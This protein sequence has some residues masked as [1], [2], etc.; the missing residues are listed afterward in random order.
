[1]L[2][3]LESCA[4]SSKNYQV[5]RPNIL[6]GAF[7]FR[8]SIVAESCAGDNLAE[9]STEKPNPNSFEI[10][11]KSTLEILKII[12]HDD[13]LVPIAVAEEMEQIAQVVDTVVNSFKRGGRLFYV[14]AGTSGR[15]GVLDAAECPPTFGTSPELVQG[16]IAGGKEALVRSVEWAED[17]E[18]EGKREIDQRKVCEKDIL[19]GITASGQ[20]PFVIGAMKRA[21]QLG[22]PVAALSCNKNSR[23]FIHADYRI[24]I[25]VG[26][27]IITGSTR[28]KSGTAQ[29]LVLNM[30]T[31]T[32]MIKMG[33]VY[34][35][36]MVDLVPVNNKLVERSKR[37]ITLATGCDQTAALQAFENSG[38][39]PK[40]AI[41]MILLSIQ[42]KEATRRLEENDGRIGLAV[43]AFYREKTD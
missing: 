39:R 9:L 12:N 1:M 7:A 11:K 32:A 3:P 15:L 28:M 20:A 38:R 25:D 13:H 4:F 22:V 16:I 17:K 31:T 35:N 42:E 24:Y 29:K 41:V 6:F 21:R 33:K 26:P 40:T 27:E 14:G 10:D 30:I 37:I 5:Q 34:N 19:I 36:L 8:T 43:E 23:T 2:L 18:I